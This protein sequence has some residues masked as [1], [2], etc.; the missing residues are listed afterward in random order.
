MHFKK[1]LPLKA[2]FDAFFSKN[3]I[4]EKN[5]YKYLFKCNSNSLDRFDNTPLNNEKLNINDLSKIQIYKNI[6]SK[7]LETNKGTYYPYSK[8]KNPGKC[9][10]ASIFVKNQKDKI[11]DIYAGTLQQISE[12]YNDLKNKLKLRIYEIEEKLIINTEKF[13]LVLQANDNKTFSDHEIR[14]D[15]SCQIKPKK[16]NIIYTEKL[17]KK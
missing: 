10:K 9:L 6:N 14:N 3:S 17:N 5:Q 2:I 7:D 8:E 12:F 1:D 16:K 11:M 15:F 13:E 4:P